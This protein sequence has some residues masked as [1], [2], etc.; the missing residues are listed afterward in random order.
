MIKCNFLKIKNPYGE[1]ERE[2][3]RER[4][5]NVLRAMS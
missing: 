5:P 3:E 2:R 4:E 1:R